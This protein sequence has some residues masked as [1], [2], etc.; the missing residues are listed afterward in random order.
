[1]A[2]DSATYLYCVVKSAR[3]PAAARA[4]HGLG[5]ASRPEAHEAGKGLWLIAAD[6]PLAQYGP[7]RLE[8]RLQDL[9]WVAT[10]AVGHEAVVEFFSRPK[11]SAVIPAKL[12]TLFSSVDKAI[13]DVAARRASIERVMKRIAGAEEW[14]IRVTR[15]PV[16]PSAEESP[17]PAP[18]TGAAFLASRKAA[19][20][21]AAS[22][23]TAA[24][25]AA[26]AAFHA[27]ARHAREATAR[28]RRPEPGTNPPVL[29]AAFLVPLSARARFK[30]E[31]RRQ[32]SACDRAAAD[33]A[34]TG[35]WPA[36][37]FVGDPA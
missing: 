24:S 5:G 12:F 29:E 27:L 18:M 31:A 37:N 13:A 26:E 3:R 14:G 30:A 33:L 7:G 21:A 11:G 2:K 4:P 19:R 36:Y 20:D 25:A 15:R 22:A 8:P 1:M 32:A 23:R 35:P 16:A 9:D 10:A 17:R 6:V 34:L 28:D